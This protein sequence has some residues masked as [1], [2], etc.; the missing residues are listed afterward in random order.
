MA[1]GRRGKHAKGQPRDEQGRFKR[2]DQAP[3]PRGAARLKQ[4]RATPSSSVKNLRAASSSDGKMPTMVEYVDLT[5]SDELTT[6]YN[7]CKLSDA[8]GSG[9]SMYGLHNLD[10]RACSDLLKRHCQCFLISLALQAWL[11]TMWILLACIA[12]LSKERS[13]ASATSELLSKRRLSS[14]RGPSATS[15]PRANKEVKAAFEFPNM[16]VTVT[17]REDS[18]NEGEDLSGKKIHA[19]ANELR[20]ALKLKVQH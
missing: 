7:L 12:A 2:A 19:M 3:S 16:K 10:R 1:G 20:R 13:S 14:T 5:T 6:R 15:D 8:I 4:I 11:G 18:D 9:N 17:Y